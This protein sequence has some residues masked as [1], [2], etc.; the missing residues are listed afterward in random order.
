VGKASLSKVEQKAETRS[1]LRMAALT[2]FATHGYDDTPVSDIAALAGV[3]D[4]TFFLHFPTKADAVMG[5]AP[6]RL[7]DALADRILGYEAGISDLELL[8]DSLLSWLEG[9]GDRRVIHHRAQL[10]LRAAALSPTV[11]GKQLEATDAM[12]VTAATALA[13]RRDLKN[14][15]LEITVAATVSIGL[16]DRITAEWATRRPSDLRSIAKAHFQAFRAATTR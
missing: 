14:P 15:N 11:R 16:F 3:S 4:R 2:L 7:L 8:E 1:R 9:A 10:V 13:R 5:I 6:D 12:I